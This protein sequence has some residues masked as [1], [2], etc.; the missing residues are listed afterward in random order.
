MCEPDRAIPCSTFHETCT[1]RQNGDAPLCQI[2]LPPP[3]PLPVV[4]RR[5][6]EWDGGL[7]RAAVR[8]L[9]D[10]VYMRAAGE[11][12]SLTRMTQSVAH[13]TAGLSRG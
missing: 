13:P 9:R 8:E 7:V 11:N 4:V 10:R 6:A 2:P 12:Y 5:G 3:L 1:E